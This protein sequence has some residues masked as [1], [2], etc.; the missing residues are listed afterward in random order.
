MHSEFALEFNV[1]K[2]LVGFDDVLNPVGIMAN[3]REN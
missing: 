2:L 1:L 3:V